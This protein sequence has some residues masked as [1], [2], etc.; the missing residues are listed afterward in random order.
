MENEINQNNYEY[1]D[2]FDN[3]NYKI[4]AKMCK[5][6]SREFGIE[7]MELNEHLTPAPEKYGLENSNIIIPSYYKLHEHPS[8]IFDFDFYRVIKDDIR[9]FRKLNQYQLEYIKNLKEE[10]KDEIIDLFNECFESI[11]ELL[12]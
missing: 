10:Y 8:K 4:Q 11:K 12:N 5:R 1:D 2:R 7:E 9:N 3:E 6:L